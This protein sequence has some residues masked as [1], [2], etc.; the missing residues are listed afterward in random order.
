ME[1]TKMFIRDTIL[2]EEQFEYLLIC[3]TQNYQ[4]AQCT[5]ELTRYHRKCP[6]SNVF[7]E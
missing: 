5:D 3:N 7:S 4:S 1:N 6:M 2:M